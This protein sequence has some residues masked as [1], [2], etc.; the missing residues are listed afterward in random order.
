MKQFRSIFKYL[1]GILFVLLVLIFF[2]WNT[3]ALIG[4]DL[5]QG[6]KAYYSY[7][8]DE[9]YM[10]IEAYFQGERPLHLVLDQKNNV[11]YVAKVGDEEISLLTIIWSDS[12]D[13]LATS[14]NNVRMSYMT[15][16]LLPVPFYERWYAW[17]FMTVRNVDL[18]KLEM[19]P[20]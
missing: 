2:F 18:D 16:I 17:L 1:M 8:P 7:A 14:Y 5:N 15:E 12:G 13:K 10:A 6:G 19:I 9:Q 3:S 20:G 11:I 4:K